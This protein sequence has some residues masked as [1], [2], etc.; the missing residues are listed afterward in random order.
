[1]GP[2][3]FDGEFAKRY[4]ANIIQGQGEWPSPENMTD[5]RGVI[6]PSNIASQ[7]KANV[8][9]VLDEITFVYVIDSEFF[10][11]GGVDLVQDCPG[12]ICFREWQNLLSYA[13]DY[14]QYDR[15]GNIST[16]DLGNPTLGPNPIFTTWTALI[17]QQS[18]TLMEKDHIIWDL[19]LTALNYQQVQLLMQVN[20]LIN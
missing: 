17:E 13:Y 18:A 6:L 12:S 19:Q 9:D 11:T 20:G 3:A 15:N 5:N 1:M 14:Y 16:R 4:G 8:G 7:A 2:E 10:D